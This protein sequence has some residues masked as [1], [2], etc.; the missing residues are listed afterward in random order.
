MN[1]VFCLNKQFSKL[2]ILMRRKGLRISRLNV[3]FYLKQI[4]NLSRIKRIR[5]KTICVFTVIILHYLM[6]DIQGIGENLC[7]KRDFLFP[8]NFCLFLN[9]VLLCISSENGAKFWSEI[10]E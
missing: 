5:I 10:V 3:I 7:I 4:E 2:T 6:G 1:S 9:T 8:L